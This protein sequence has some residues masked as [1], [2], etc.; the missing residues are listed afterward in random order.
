[1]TCKKD[2]HHKHHDLDY[3]NLYV[4]KLM[5]SF[6]SKGY[7]NE[8][9]NWGWF[10]YYLTNE[11][12]SYLREYLNVPEEFMPGT[13]KKVRN[14]ARERM[15]AGEERRGGFRGG[16]G[17]GGRGGFGGDKKT[18]GA[19]GGFTPSY[20]GEGGRGG[21]RSDRGGRGRG[22]PRGGSAAPSQ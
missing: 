5:Q 16:R 9:Y 14:V 13:L 18:D 17:G 8:T 3:P 15:P 10:Y 11:G 6:A 20:G 2:P 1:M 21:Y 12:I 19:P 4:M 7:C 22:A